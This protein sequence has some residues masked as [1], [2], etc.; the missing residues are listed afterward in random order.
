M[1]SLLQKCVEEL[2]KDEP[3]ATEP[4]ELIYKSFAKITGR[5]ISF[6]ENVWE[7]FC[8]KGKEIRNPSI[9]RNDRKWSDDQEVNVMG[10]FH[11]I[12]CP[13]CFK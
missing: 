10:T 4:N 8:K 6:I 3:A 7:E 2:K 9:D 5:P 11:Q 13:R 1:Y 12:F